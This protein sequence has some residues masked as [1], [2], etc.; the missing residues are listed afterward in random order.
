VVSLGNFVTNILLAR[1]LS[2][3]DY[4]AFAFVYVVIISLNSAQGAVI[5]YPLTIMGAVEKARQLSSTTAAAGV[6][7]TALAVPFGLGI[8]GT[9]LFV[10]KL[11]LTLPVIAA[12]LFWQ[13]QETVRRGMMAH[14]RYQEVIYGDALSYLGQAAMIW[15]AIRSDQLSLPLVFVFIAVTSGLAA[16]LQAVQLRCF[17]TTVHEVGALARAFWEFGRWRLLTS[18]VMLLTTAAGPGWLGMLTFFRGSQ[19][20]AAMQAVANPL[21]LGHPLM[22][23]ITSLIIPTTAR[24]RSEH[25]VLAATWSALRTARV[26]AAFLL[27]YWTGLLILP[28]TILA[29][30]YGANSAYV[31]LEVPL[32]LMVLTYVVIYLNQVV[33]A[34]LLG[35]GDSRG[36][37]LF[38]L[39]GAV[40]FLVAAAPLSAIYGVSGASAGCILVA[41]TQLITSTRWFK[42]LF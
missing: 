6:L 32:R 8:L 14:V 41:L 40:A 3:T 35:L 25:G 42:R 17:R 28:A 13:I 4:G 36:V 39:A 19:E 9:C 11:E 18:M 23:G 1:S 37:F 16:M 38:S 7:T 26:G 22:L 33:T 5:T 24:M 34:L 20:A 10:G 2:V 30:F 31:G 27:P 15:A 12:V 21:G 29:L